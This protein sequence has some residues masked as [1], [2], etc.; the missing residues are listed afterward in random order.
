MAKG[1]SVATYLTRVAQVKDKLAVVGEFIPDSDLV[2]IS[3][4]GFTKEWEVFEKCVVGRENLPNLSILWDD[5]TYEEIWERSQEKALDG[6]DENNVAL[7]VKGNEK[8]KYMSKVI[9]FACH[10]TGHYPS[11]CL[12]KKK[13]KL[14]PKMSASA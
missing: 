14:E 12:N 6:A 11:Q 1:E 2:W 8:K 7:V 9:F 4:K 10:K 13:K 3:L 5:F